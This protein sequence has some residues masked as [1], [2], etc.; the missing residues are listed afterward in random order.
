MACGC[1][2][3]KATATSPTTSSDKKAISSNKKMP[4]VSIASKKNVKDK[5]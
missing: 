3:K 5:K 2:K 1:K 4:L